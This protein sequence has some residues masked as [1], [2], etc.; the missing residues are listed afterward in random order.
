MLLCLYI[1]AYIGGRGREGAGRRGKTV[2][3]SYDIFIYMFI[4]EEGA[5]RE[6]IGGGRRRTL[7][8]TCDLYVHMNHV[9]YVPI[10]YFV[11]M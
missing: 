9:W 6:P 11:G 1:Y 5:R 4:S 7:H 10:K 3:L 8:F 2:L